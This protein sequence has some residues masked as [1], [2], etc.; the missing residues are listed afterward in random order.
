MFTTY[1]ELGFEH[2][3]DLQGYDHIVFLIALCAAYRFDD[4][5]NILILVTAFTI[6]HSI[7]LA[8]SSLSVIT[9]NADLIEILIPITILITA[10]LN[11]VTKP[12]PEKK[13]RPNY[14]LALF[15]GFIHGM[16]F[17][18]FFKALLGREA[19]I[20]GP[21]FAFNVGVELGQL[22]IVAFIM[23]LNF[24]VVKL[25]KV[26]QR[27][28]NIVVSIIALLLSVYMIIGKL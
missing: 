20:I 23:F 26:E 21:L 4:W 12:D 14:F 16:G 17:S 15:F 27:H 11:L 6:G 8:L 19:E 3:L 1:L 2:I 28:W 5:K 25:G 7:T 9:V 13:W 24:L 22:C 18:N 10:I